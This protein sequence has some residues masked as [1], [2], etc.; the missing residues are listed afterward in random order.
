[1]RYKT[2]S[3]F[4]LCDTRAAVMLRSALVRV[5]AKR[6][7]SIRALG[8]QLGY[9]QATVISHMASGRIPVPLERAPDIARAVELPAG[10][11]LAACVEQ[12][13]PE[14]RLL[15]AP[16]ESAESSFGLISELSLIGGCA[17]DDLTQEQKHV[18]REVVADPSPKRRWLGVAELPA[19]EL[20]RML[21]PEIT[22]DGLS[23]TDLAA[24]ENVLSNTMRLE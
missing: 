21:R 8:K 3:D 20:I 2:E 13:S 16:S 14:A 4:P 12:R 17:L 6:G 15:L 18:L 1:M 22:Q 23:P 11:F 7:L 9:K 5:H 19:V 24:I 10:D